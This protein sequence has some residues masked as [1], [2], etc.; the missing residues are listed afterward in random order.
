MIVFTSDIDWAPDEIIDYTL[1][2]F[3]KYGVKATLFATHASPEITTCNKSLFETAIHPNFNPLLEGKNGTADDVIDRLLDIYPE[4]KGVRSHCML[5]SFPLLNK[6]ADKKLMYDSNQFIPYADGV[7]PFSIWNGMVRIPYNWEDDIHF[8]Y[9]YPF[10][11]SRIDLDSNN[12]NVFDFHPIHIFLNTS[13]EEDYL[14]AKKYY[15]DPDKL[16]GFRNNSKAGTYDLLISLL[17]SVK[18][19]NLNSFTMKEIAM[20]YQSS[21]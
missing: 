9:K 5:Q 3:E 21:K 6:F 10:N 7:T 20:K 11:N 4:A 17:E 2:I 12:L 19:E 8:I 14:N 18:S 15:Q 1:S 16:K 13:S